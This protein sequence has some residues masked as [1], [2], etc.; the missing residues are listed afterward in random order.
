[1]KTISTAL[2]ALLFTGTAFAQTTTTTTT[3]APTD[4]TPLAIGASLPKGDVKM[5]NVMSGKDVA[6]N[7][8]KGSK[9]TLVI[10]ACT[11]CPYVIAN[12]D[13]IK[14]AIKKAKDLG[15]GAVVVNSN[16]AKRGDDDS[17]SAMKKYGKKQDY[18]CAYLVDVNSGLADAFGAT[19]TPEC[20]LFDATGKL[21]YHGAIDDNPKEASAA[22]T[23]Y[24][25]DAMTA[26]AKGDAVKVQTSRS[27][28]CSIKRKSV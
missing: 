22:T 5:K 18:T 24:L 3:V 12:E 17:E 13:R 14:A 10:F 28:G 16:E 4:P 21:V 20:F 1:M 9:G 11:S 23:N 27:V 8:L 25:N 6:L 15:F 19:R 2:L 7:D 26:S